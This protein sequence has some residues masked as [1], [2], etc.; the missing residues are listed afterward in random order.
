LNQNF[1]YITN[2]II[3]LL[4]LVLVYLYFSNLFSREL[5]NGKTGCIYVLVSTST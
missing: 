4:L 2:P 3:A 1:I 5:R